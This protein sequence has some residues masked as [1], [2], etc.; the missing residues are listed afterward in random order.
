MN[1]LYVLLIAILSIIVVVFGGFYL[2]APNDVVPRE[3]KD[4]VAT[5]ILIPKDEKIDIAKQSYKYD[6]V[7]ELLT[8]NATYENRKL[9]ITQQ[10]TPEGFTDIPQAYDS[11]VSQM[12][13]YA[14]FD[15][16]IGVVYLTSPKDQKNVQIAVMNTK[17]TLVFVKV[18][19][20][21]SKQEWMKFFGTFEI[22]K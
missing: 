11:L 16:A 8:F 6:G 2:L 15:A 7:N 20:G 12:G 17:G 3:V 9:V 4:Q 13:E 22:A 5:T 18:A 21:M 19:G 14:K 10:P 1:R